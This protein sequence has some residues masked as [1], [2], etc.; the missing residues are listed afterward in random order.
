MLRDVMH[1]R[2]NRFGSSVFVGLEIM[3]R[4]KLAEKNEILQQNSRQRLLHFPNPLF[5][6]AVS[7]LPR[8]PA[9]NW[10]GPSVPQ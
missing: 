4:A 9:V 3:A 7:L 6:L 10:A 2:L 8:A 1:R 5:I